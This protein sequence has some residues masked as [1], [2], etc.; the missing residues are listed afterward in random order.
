MALVKEA[1]QDGKPVYGA[2]ITG[3][4][5]GGTVCVLASAG[6]D[7]AAAVEEVARRYKVK[8][9]H[10]SYVFSGSSIGASAFGFLRLKVSKK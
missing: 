2:K 7:G 8:S 1:Q 4:G 6:A 10:T 3:G 5:S 9:T